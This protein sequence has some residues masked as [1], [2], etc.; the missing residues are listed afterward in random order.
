MFY[1]SLFSPLQFLQKNQDIIQQILLDLF[2]IPFLLIWTHKPQ[3]S[4]AQ[5]VETETNS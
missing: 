4:K 1:S 2:T 3:V 5:F